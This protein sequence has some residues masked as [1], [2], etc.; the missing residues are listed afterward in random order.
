MH[1][2]WS[3]LH[4]NAFAGQTVLVT[5]GVGFIGSHLCD[6]L[7]QLGA[8]VH[9]F[10]DCSGG[11]RRNLAD[12]K[13]AGHLSTRTGSI[14]DEH[15]VQQA[16]E[17][18]TLVFHQ[19][20]MPSVPR[21]ITMPR[22][23]H[24]VNVTGTQ[25]VFDAAVTAGVQRIM[26]AASSSAYGDT[27]TLPKTESMPPRP[28]SPYAANKVAGECLVHAYANCFDL[29]GVALRYFN[30]FGPRQNANSAYAGVIAA[31][32]RQILQ[33]QCPKVHGDGKQTR[34]FT[35][36]DNAVHANLLAA[37]STTP[38]GGRVLNVASGQA[39]TVGE[40]A[41][42]MAEGLNRPDLRPEHGASRPG[43]VL[44]SLASL[45]QVEDALEYQPIVNFQEGLAQ[46]I[47]WYRNTMAV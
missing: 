19:A 37:R 40:L 28:K 14:L 35:Y 46:T 33:G 25:I 26:F 17:G 5:G 12:I 16:M 32:A 21:S 9:A 20:A 44:H 42:R 27:P 24:D 11:D 13:G 34:D 39:V 30:I 18:R 36:V 47:S 2:N 43:D 3:D 23:Y 1:T 41:L 45:D 7:V 31:F 22:R 15:A 4:G 10:D 29:D 6:A 38:L 8:D